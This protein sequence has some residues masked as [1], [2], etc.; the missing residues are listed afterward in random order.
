VSSYVS[1]TETVLYMKVY[2]IRYNVII[3]LYADH[4]EHENN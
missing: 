2:Y 1:I 3:N 4:W